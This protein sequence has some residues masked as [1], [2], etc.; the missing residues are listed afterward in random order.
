[1]EKKNIQLGEIPNSLYTE[2]QLNYVNSVKDAHLRDHLLHQVRLR[3]NLE[4]DRDAFEK[5]YNDKCVEYNNLLTEYN[6]YK[7]SILISGK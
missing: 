6:N 5:L 3:D 1:M 7:Y 2:E 4:K